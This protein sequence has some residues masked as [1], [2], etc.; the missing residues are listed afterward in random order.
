MFKTPIGL[1][2]RSCG[3]HPRAAD[4]VGHQRLR[5][6]LRRPSSFRDPGRDGRGLPLD[7]LRRTRS[8][9]TMT[10]GTGLHRARCADLRQLAAV[11]RSAAARLLFGFSTRVSPTAPERRTRGRSTA[12]LRS[13][14]VPAHAHRRR[15][16][17][18][19]L[20]P[21]RRRWS[22]VREAVAADAPATLARGPP[23]S[24]AGLGAGAVPA[25]VVAL[26]V[27]E[28]VTLVQSSASGAA[29]L[30]SRRVRDRAG[31]AGP[32]DDRAD[33]GAG[34]G[35]AQRGRPAYSAAVGLCVGITVGLAVGFYGL[36]TL[37]AE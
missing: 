6:P 1:R 13:A 32:R 7:R 8:R 12:A 14:A 15:R 20:D 5:R 28:T 31:P 29:R 18:R 30:R 24:S 25:G 3:E 2:I 21:A 33:A 10:A 36:L 17:D 35:A 19:P 34:G 22:P 9:R 27:L 23:S 26:L 4:T 37:F 16:R 11:R